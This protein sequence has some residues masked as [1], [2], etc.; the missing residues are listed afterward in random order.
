MN[1]KKLEK[2]QKAS[3]KMQDKLLSLVSKKDRLI[4]NHLLVSIVGMEI[5][6]EAQ[7]NQ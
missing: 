3:D 7:C 6:I 5:E 1:K 4:A 2:M